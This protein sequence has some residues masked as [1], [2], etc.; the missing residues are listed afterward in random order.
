[1]SL[2]IKKALVEGSDLVETM[3]AVGRE[4]VSTRAAIMSHFLEMSFHLN[5]I[6]IP[7]EQLLA[8][9]LRSSIMASDLWRQ[10]RS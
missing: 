8:E 3:V 10:T 7:S 9:W 4:Y 6:L 1:M 5:V 2:A